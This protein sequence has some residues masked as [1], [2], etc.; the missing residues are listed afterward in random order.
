MNP[1]VSICLP[2]LNMLPFLRERFDTIF[3]QTLQD[4]ELFVYDSQSNDGGWEYIQQLARREKRMRIAQ[5]P[6]EGPYPAWNECLRQTNAE[7]VYFATS[8]DTMAPNCLEKMVAALEQHP[9][10]DLAHCSLINIDEAGAPSIEL[11]WP[12]CTVFGNGNGEILA[13]A[14]VRR[15]PYDGLLH[16][17]G[18][19]VY[20]SFT[21]L[22]IR[23]SLFSR[24]G[25]FP[26]K[27][28]PASDFNW[29]MKAGLVANTVHVPATWATWRLHPGQLT[30]QTRLT[31]PA[32]AERKIEE[33]IQ[34]A[35]A[36]CQTLLQPAVLAGLR[37]YWL[38]RTRD[39][40]AYYYALWQSPG[41]LSRR[42]HQARKVLFGPSAARSEVMSRMFGRAK[43][44]VAGPSEL[45]AWLESLGA[46]P[47]AP[48]ESR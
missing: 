8:D 11:R 32:E 41:F 20:L 36:G 15:A 42:L 17:M 28:G 27:W 46:T 25:N 44:P 22:L 38:E 16:L 21:Q 4:W 24:I 6:R 10:C 48:S 5:G 37:S 40:R 12:D 13:R 18:R 2:N 1:R 35:V 45:S 14:H 34:D 9:E 3:G 7:F 39:L 30:A 33:M 19:H 43:W 31:R 29:E 47:V 26:S 23:R